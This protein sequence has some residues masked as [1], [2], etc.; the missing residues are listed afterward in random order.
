MKRA[1][2][3]SK[4]G[5][6]PTL[7]PPSTPVKESSPSSLQTALSESPTNSA[8]I[9][10]NVRRT[11]STGS[12]QCLG[13]SPMTLSANSSTMA[14]SASVQKPLSSAA[15][16]GALSASN[17]MNRKANS[18]VASSN[19]PVP[20]ARGASYAAALL[21]GSGLHSFEDSKSQ[22]SLDMPE[23]LGSMSHSPIA[24]D[25]SFPSISSAHGVSLL[26]GNSSAGDV[27]RPARAHSE[28]IVKFEGSSALD[29]EPVPFDFNDFTSSHAGLGVIQ[30]SSNNSSRSPSI[31]LPQGAFS[32]NISWLSGATTMSFETS[33]DNGISQKGGSD[34]LFG[35]A[36]SNAQVDF[37]NSTLQF[38]QNVQYRAA[39]E[40]DDRSSSLFGSPSSHQSSF[41]AGRMRASSLGAL[42]SAPT[43]ELWAAMLA[44]QSELSSMNVPP[45]VT[46]QS[47]L[48]SRLF[49]VS[50]DEVNA[51][52]WRLSENASLFGTTSSVP[53]FPQGVGVKDEGVSRVLSFTQ[54]QQANASK[55]T[56]SKSLGD[57]S[58]QTVSSYSELRLDSP[59]F[60]PL[61]SQKW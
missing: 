56:P 31:V 13:S 32:N 50:S 46:S 42:G 10:S 26:N 57:G 4:I 24:E 54:T 9:R 51:S 35:T 47:N 34:A 39:S 16:T 23:N 25:S 22:N 58:G 12:A 11:M 48:A 38:G 45:T 52:P 5:L 14:A 53:P 28:P 36:S 55:I 27:V 44:S 20:P 61:S 37:L 8:N 40:Q 17:S 19:P 41:N 30:P 2:P 43:P 29:G 60:Q 3:R 21:M 33:V 18:T 49:A 59:E 1:I 6:Q 7:Q 15:S